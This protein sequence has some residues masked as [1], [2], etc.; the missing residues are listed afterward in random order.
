MAMPGDLVGPY[1]LVERL[2]EGGFGQVWLAEQREP[3]RRR[4]ALKLIKPGMDSAE[5]LARFA[6]ERQALALMDHPGVAKVFDAGLTSA[7]RPYF[8]MEYVPGPPI[9][10]FCDQARMTPRERI[11]LFIRVCLAVHHAH[12]KGIIHRD[13]KP[14]NILVSNVDAKPEPKVIDFG[15]AKAVS[16]QLTDRTLHTGIGRLLG[17]PE[18]MAPEQAGDPA[19]AS[20]QDIDT[21]ADVYSLGVVLYELLAG[22][23]PFDSREL[24]GAAPDSIWR[25]ILHTDP[26]KPSTR[27]LEAPEAPP[28]DPKTPARMTSLREIARARNTDPRQLTRTI[29]GDL[30]WIVMKCLEKDRTRRYDSAA[31]LAQDLER[32]LRSEPV[33]AGPPSV[34]YRTRKFVRRHRVGV[35]V[36]AGLATTLVGALALTSTFYV[37]AERQRE[38][39]ERESARSTAALAIVRDMFHS[40]EPAVAQGKPALVRDVLDAA[41]KQMN[42]GDKGDPAVE[43]TVRSLIGEAY[44]ELGNY[45]LAE[46]Q[47]RKALE[48]SERSRGADDP[49][50]MTLRNNLAA[51]LIVQSR[52]DEVPPVLDRAIA[53][54]SRVLGPSH[55]DTLASKSLR[56]AY[57][58][59]MDK[60]AEA[61]PLVRQI[62][63]EQSAAIGPANP[64]TLES[65]LSLADIL[66]QIGKHAEAEKEAADIARVAGKALGAEH[67]TTL[68]ALGIEASTMEV[69]G[70]YAEAEPVVRDLLARRKRALG[71]D[72]ASTLMT[73]DQLGEILS[74]ENKKDEALALRREAVERARRVLG[75]DH[76]NTA[77]YEHNLASLLHTMGKLDEAE[78]L[79]RSVYESRTKIYGERSRPALSTLNQIGL[80]LLDRKQPEQAL[81]LL[82]Q[83]LEGLQKDLPADHWMLGASRTCVAECLLELKRYDEAE[84]LLKDAYAQLSR[85]F[86]A[87]HP[88]ATR[89]AGDL[90]KVYEGLSRESDAADWRA[91]AAA[92]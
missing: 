1:R 79:Y 26:P 20:G 16:Q 40:V 56:I 7:G 23:L 91:K 47:I 52:L 72:H 53:D 46:P 86:N 35:G 10:A 76:V 77:T 48:L 83:V 19:G 36:V 13:L 59:R 51:N 25:L 80:L 74:Q 8:A 42:T 29:R 82:Q 62:I 12:Q 9:T 49:E 90:V 55:A 37:R 18:Y 71:A 73:M 15:V 34:G 33:L 17:T 78:S 81:P 64:E 88:R 43:S 6:A 2:G 32:H 24:R 39:A 60:H 31:S 27:L 61:E 4:V 38:L 14:S 28:P 58:Q 65:R 85:T 66:N 57:L 50:T 30:D 44:H 69:Q 41:A 67:P 92:Q 75:R 84:P 45:D 87:A 22:V 68:S 11:E 70:R 89:A 63:A 21:R 54:R 5:V 3:I